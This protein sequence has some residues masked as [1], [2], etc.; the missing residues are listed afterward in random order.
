MTN[1]SEKAGEERLL[2]FYAVFATKNLRDVIDNEIFERLKGIFDEIRG[3][4]PIYVTDWVAAPYYLAIVTRVSIMS[5]LPAVLR[6]FKKESDRQIRREFP[7]LEEK[8]QGDNFWMAA[9][10]CVP[11][12]PGSHKVLEDYIESA[13]RASQRH[14]YLSTGG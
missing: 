12:G 9:F 14:G 10:C 13:R 11:E 4:S 5:G 2:T 6:K 7:R 8:L 1:I 3:D